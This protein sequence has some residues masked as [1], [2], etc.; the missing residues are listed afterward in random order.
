MPNKMG[1]STLLNRVIGCSA[2]I[3]VSSEEL[4]TELTDRILPKGMLLRFPDHKIYITDGINT[5]D[6]LEPIVDKL[7]TEVEKHS[8]ALAFVNGT[9]QPIEGGVVVHSL[10][11][12]IDD[13]ELNLV[14]DGKLKNSYLSEIYEN[15]RIK[16]EVL[17]DYL[18]ALDT[19]KTDTLMKV[20]AA[21]DS[22]LAVA[23]V[24][25]E[26]SAA[27]SY[28]ATAAS[29]SQTAVAAAQVAKDAA[30]SASATSG[31]PEFTSADIGKVITVSEGVDQWVL[32]DASV[33]KMYKQIKHIRLGIDV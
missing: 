5:I 3:T 23:P 12:K 11:G 10:N 4:V 26:I 9:Y 25:D 14:E 21:L 17:P 30:G 2:I 8:L 27:P 33:N 29:S 13:D 20:G 6:K 28:A 16:V 15:G 7:L 19:S 22:I 18:K 32:S 1:S 24:V 31:L